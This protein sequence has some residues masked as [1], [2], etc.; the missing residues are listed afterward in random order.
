MPSCPKKSPILKEDHKV[1]LVTVAT[2]VLTPLSWL[3]P[4]Y[5]LTHGKD[6]A[7]AAMAHK[8]AGS[9]QTRVEGEDQALFISQMPKTGTEALSPQTP[10]CCSQKRCAN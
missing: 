2:S 1:T 3:R 5:T 4:L 10:P 9:G 7:G 6:W 8:P